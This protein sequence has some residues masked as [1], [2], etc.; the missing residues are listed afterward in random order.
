MTRLQMPSVATPLS[1]DT[2]MHIRRQYAEG[3]SLAKIYIENAVNKRVV[4]RCIA[5]NPPGLSALPP[6]PFRWTGTTEPQPDRR[7]VIDRL[8]RSAKREVRGT[9]QRLA[10]LP[11]GSPEREREVRVL[12]VLVKVVR[13]LTALDRA[14]LQKSASKETPRDDDDDALPRDLEELRRELSRRVDLLR[15]RRPAAGRSGGDAA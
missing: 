10:R 15:Q 7:A 6:L 14:Q 11:G 3:V 4:Y 5:G 1:L 13:D 2:V 9:D 12:P 8:W